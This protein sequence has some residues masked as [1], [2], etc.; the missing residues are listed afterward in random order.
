[1]WSVWSE[2]VNIY[3]GQGVALVKAG[4]QETQVLLHTATLPLDRVL[5]KVEQALPSKPHR[6]VRR[7]LRITLSGALCPAMVFS[8]PPEVS[9]W[10]ELQQIAIA[11]IKAQAPIGMRLRH[12]ASA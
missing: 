10:S 11:P 8:A 12:A 5:A 6:K 3:V 1:M 9:R 2:S 7:D 4:K